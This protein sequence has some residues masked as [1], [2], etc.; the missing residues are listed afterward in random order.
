MGTQTDQSRDAPPD[1]PNSLPI[2]ETFY[3]VQGEGKLSGVPSFFI[4]V[5]GCNLRCTWCDTPYA[6]WKPEFTLHSIAALVEQV[7]AT[8]AKH[9]VLT[10]GEPMIFPL[11]ADLAASL[12]AR[13]VHITIETA[14]TVFR[15]VAC[16]LISISPKL[17]NSTPQGD[18]RD[19]LKV[20]EAR[21][22]ARRLNFVALQAL[23]DHYPQRQLKFVVRA[24]DDGALFADLAEIDSVLARLHHWSPTD[25]LLMLE[26]TALPT[27]DS[28]QRVVEACL[29]R[30]WRYC[31][32]LHI[33]L[34]GNTRGT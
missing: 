17:A 19:P 33:E 1:R 3:S 28:K 7:C 32:R 20:W 21:H 25:V 8:P 4:R 9:A 23:I 12:R 5:S 18:E 2:S 15:D 31:P 6:S 16:D 14:G 26:G 24:G 29:L 30:G 27:A 11:I 10:G 22:E 34:F 13:G